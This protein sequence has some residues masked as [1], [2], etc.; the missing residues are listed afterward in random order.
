MNLLG[1]TSWASQVHTCPNSRPKKE[2]GVC[3]RDISGLMDM[4]S[5][6]S[7]AKSWSNTPLCTT[8]GGQDMVAVLAPRGAGG[9][10]RRLQ[11]QK[12]VTSGWLIGYQGNLQRG[13]YFTTTLIRTIIS[14]VGR[15]DVNRVRAK[16]VLVEQV[17]YKEQENSH[18]EWSD[19]TIFGEI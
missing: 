9:G 6:K 2:P 12:E 3:N 10:C 16:Q 11:F 17:M 15:S 7:E 18:P 4:G 1:C 13:T 19:Y 8:D 14:K 5:Y